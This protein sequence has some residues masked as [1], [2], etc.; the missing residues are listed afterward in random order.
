[1]VL[2][3]LVFVLLLTPL[4][5]GEQQS[6]GTYKRNT[7]VNLI[8]TCADCTYVNFTSVLYPNSTQL[9]GNSNSTQTGTLFERQICNTTA[10][11]TYIVNGVGDVSGTDTIF[12]YVFEITPNGKKE[13]N[14][15]VSLAITFFFIIFNVGMFLMYFMKDKYHENK[16]V[17]FMIKRGVLII[18]IF[19]TMFT[20]SIIATLVAA[21]NYD[22]MAQM[23]GLMDIVGWAGYASIIL[24]LFSTTFQT[25]NELNHDKREKRTGGEYDE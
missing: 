19:F 8:Q 17:N 18:C 10:V 20:I 5:F 15:P 22:L 21:S 25:L 24:L 23:H 2:I 9:I 1:M 14:S 3:T 12:A 7:C 16:Y 6:L 11:G 4:V 13:S